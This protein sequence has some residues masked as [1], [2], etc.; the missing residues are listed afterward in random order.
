MH[1]EEGET[2]MDHRHFVVS[3]PTDGLFLQLGATFS[4]FSFPSHPRICG[5]RVRSGS[6]FVFLR[7]L[8]RPNL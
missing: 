2:K 5:R 4:P 3:T 7:S 1:E 8:I 6:M